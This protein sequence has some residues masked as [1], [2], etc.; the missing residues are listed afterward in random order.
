MD[1][2]VLFGSPI[3]PTPAGL[4]RGILLVVFWLLLAASCLAQLGLRQPA[5]AQA[6]EDVR[7]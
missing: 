5:P 7:A 6:R 1:A 4:L 2:K 3:H